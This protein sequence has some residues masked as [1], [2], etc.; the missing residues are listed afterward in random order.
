MTTMMIGLGLPGGGE[1]VMILLVALVVFG[2]RLPEVA[3]SLGKGVV[4]FKRGL[5]GIEDDID[6]AGEGPRRLNDSK[7]TTDEEKKN[8]TNGGA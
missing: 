8:P 2:R 4:E 6:R 5:S 7:G 3:R 1:W